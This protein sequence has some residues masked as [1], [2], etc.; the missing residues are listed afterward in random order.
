MVC[1]FSCHMQAA[2]PLLKR[3]PNLPLQ[4]EENGGRG[5]QNFPY[6]AH[7]ARYR[8]W[9]GVTENRLVWQ[10][11]ETHNAAVIR[12][13]FLRA[14]RQGHV[15]GLKP[16]AALTNYFLGQLPSEWHAGLK[17]YA[18]VG[19]YDIYAGVD[20]VYRTNEDNLEY[21]FVIRPGGDPSAIQLEVSGA[22]EL[23]INSAGDLV[24]GSGVRQ[25]RWKR[26]VVYQDA[27]DGRKPVEGKFELNGRRVRFHV[28]SYD[29]KRRLVID[30]VLKYASYVGAVGGL[31]STT[32]S[33]GARGIGTDAAGNVYIA[34]ASSDN[35]LPV[36]PGVVQT[37]YNGGTSAFLSGDVFVAKFSPVGKLQYL[38]FLGGRQDDVA[39]SM[40][41]DSAGDAYVAGYTTS[42][43][44]PVT[45]G[46]L[47]PK[48]AGGGGNV[49]SVYGDG[50]VAKLNPSGTQLLYSTYLGGSLDDGI[51]AIA[52]DAA[53]NA[54]VTGAT[55]SLNFPLQSPLQPTMHGSGGEPGT[56]DCNGAPFQDYGDAFVAKLNPTASALVFSTYLGGSKDDA[57]TAIAL[58]SAENV[59]VGG[60]TL[61]PDF[62]TTAGAFQ[63]VYHGVD[64]ENQFQNTGDAFIAKLNS[65]GS[66]LLYSTYLGGTGDDAIASIFVDRADT[67]YVTG[68]TSSRDFPVTPTAVQSRFAGYIDLPYVIANNYGDAFVTRLNQTGTALL[69]SSYLGG[70]HNDE[71]GGIWVDPSG[72][73]YVVGATDSMDFPVTGNAVQ[74]A[75]AGDDDDIEA[76]YRPYGDGFLTIIDP[77]ST[78]PVYSTYYGGTLDDV[79]LGLAPDLN[80]N[81]WITGTTGSSDFKV[82]SN[83]FQSSYPGIPGISGDGLLVEFSPTGPNAPTISSVANAASNVLNLVAPGMVFVLYGQNLGPSTLTGSAIDPAT[84]LLSG[85]VAEVSVLFNNIPSPLVYV[86]NQ[87]VAGTVPYEV[88]GLTTVQVVVE[89]S[90]VR[91]APF[92]VQVVPSAPGLFSVDF[93]GKGQAVIYNA[94]NTVNSASNPAHR[95]SIIQI[96]ATGEG[97]TV[98]P[99]QDG[100]FST[101]TPPKPVL[102]VSA[103]IGGVPQTQ[104]VYIGAIPGE[105]PGILQV[106]LT[107]DPSTPTGEQ[108]IVVQVGSAS[109]QAGLT[110]AIQ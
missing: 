107:V 106:N 57:G 66:A 34:G 82:T 9:I 17:N 30:P 81:I 21:D 19:V 60:A 88:I 67:V 43:N 6:V 73:I 15:V 96:F 109:S 16:Q 44:F 71:G 61:S 14:N 68:A 70:A 4:F 72:L 93:S 41:V 87:Q 78:V 101:G 105:P 24:S 20:L 32:G 94:D 90:G 3:A 13:R 51:G 64:P 65:S 39:L 99:G 22:S 83:A 42:S 77:A 5:P 100:L 48:F 86:L 10:D 103:T 7:G 2:A 92:S 80:G 56:P 53:G 52:I 1:I 38:T 47:Q 75:F 104:F 36:T 62:P 33:N 85:T 37:G 110:V 98:P 108:P 29:R 79:F 23:R 97:Q 50:F 54:Y 28:G 59:Y 55:L 69:Y 40:A 74:S 46:V 18:E 27:A 11:A 45:A 63:T 76:D 58:D 91:S 31:N 95:G 89:V 84:G 35:Y 25:V 49:C 26:P 102:P 8:M 12:T